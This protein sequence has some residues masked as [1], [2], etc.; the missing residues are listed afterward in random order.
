MPFRQT[1]RALS[2][3]RLLRSQDH[4]LHA[5]KVEEALLLHDAKTLHARVYLRHGYIAQSALAETGLIHPDEDPYQNHA[6]YFA[7]IRPNAGQPQ[8]VATARQIHAHLDHGHASFPMVR[9]LQLYPQAQKLIQSIDPAT[10]VEVSA[11]AKRAGE[12]SLATLLLYRL[13]WQHSVKV[14]HRYWFMACDARVYDR[15]L[16]LFG[17]AFIQAGPKTFYMGSDVI[18]ALLEIPGSVEH[19]RQEARGLNI[20]KRHFRR[21]TVE[22]FLKGMPTPHE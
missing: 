8:V 20:I 12:S 14:G 7:V 2:Y 13:M 9:H 1:Q 3:L 19:L 17:K 18:P 15:L 10:C 6:Q 21:S 22:F 16:F 4:D 11:L 5:V